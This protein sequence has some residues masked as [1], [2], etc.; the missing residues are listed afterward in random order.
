M[1]SMERPP[2]LGIPRDVGALGEAVRYDLHLCHPGER[3]AA[4]GT[5]SPST[6]HL[7]GLPPDPLTFH[8]SNGCLGNMHS[9]GMLARHP[10]RSP[11]GQPS[12]WHTLAAICRRSDILYPR[13][14]GGGADTLDHDGRLLGFLWSSTEPSQVHLRRVRATSEG[15]GWLLPY[16]GDAHWSPTDPVLRSATCQLPASA[17][18]LASSVREGGNMSGRMAGMP[19]IARGSSG[20]VKGGPGRYTYILHVDLQDVSRCQETSREDNTKLLLARFP[21]QGVMGDGARCVDYHVP[22]C[23]SRR[24]RHTSPSTYQHGSSDPV[25][26]ADDATFE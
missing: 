23:V 25:G 10:I 21:V 2:E 16:L 8:P 18:G 13:I 9:A 11:V 1:I 12:Q 3:S 5:N 19:P 6:R 4:R 22:T 24:A 17:L 15:D 26:A 7:E 20:S 14:H